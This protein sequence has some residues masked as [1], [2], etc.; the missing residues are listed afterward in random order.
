MPAWF[1]PDFLPDTYFSRSV[2]RRSIL[3]TLNRS[4]NW[5]SDH[6]PITARRLYGHRPELAPNGHF[7]GALSGGH[8]Q[9]SCRWLPEVPAISSRC[10]EIGGSPS[11][12]LA[13]TGRWSRSDRQLT[14]KYGRRYKK[15]VTLL[16][17][18]MPAVVM[19]MRR[20]EFEEHLTH[21]NILM[22]VAA[23]VMEYEEEEERQRRKCAARRR[24]W[25]R[26]WLARRPIYGHYEQLMNELLRENHTDFQDVPP[27]WAR[28]VLRVGRESRT[29][30]SEEY[31]VS[32]TVS[33]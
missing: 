14:H 17:P 9:G 11:S 27:S 30:D 32:C 3:V 19:M 15:S 16:A 18:V 29:K 31:K 4:D 7:S 1:L 23:I 33:W 20:R 25:V 24:W 13:A 12:D 6:L 8:W 28:D 2:A 22:G 10:R 5:V 21:F 26:P